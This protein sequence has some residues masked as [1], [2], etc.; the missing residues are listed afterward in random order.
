MITLEDDE[1]VFRFPEVH[2]DAVCSI[3]LQRTLRI[4]DDDRDYPLPPGLGE[5]PLRHLDDYARNIPDRWLERGGV[6][7]PMH[8]AEAMWI[9]FGGFHGS[10]YPFAIKIATGKINAISGEAWVPNLNADPQDYVVVPDQPWLDGY[11]VERGLIRQFVA[12]PLGSGYS[13]EEQLTGKGEHG[14]IQIVAYPMKASRYEEMRKSRIAEANVMR[15]MSVCESAEPDMGL[16]PGGRMKQEIYD[17]DYGLDAW[18]Q[19]HPSKCFVTIANSTTWLAITGE[20]PPTTPPSA[21]D[22]TDAGLPWFELFDADARALEG[23]AELQKLASVSQLG[24]KKGEA[25]LAD[26]NSVDVN[27]I[28]NLRKPGNNTVRESAL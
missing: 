1:L 25:P 13:A 6:I 8:Q 17:D 11:C 7:M 28:I 4:P 18:D 21:S 12:M 16:A 26:N 3:S 9:E 27:R 20:V 14:G 24:K 19:R 22:Y 15:C 5:F 23:A 10:G 2:E